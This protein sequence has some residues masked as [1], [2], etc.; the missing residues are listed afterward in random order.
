MVQLVYT[1][2]ARSRM[3]QRHIT[4]EEAQE[5]W[6][7]PEIAYADRRGNL[8]HVGRVRGRRIKVVVARGSDPPKVITVAD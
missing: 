5:A 3:Q 4:E 6:D 2:H 1:A 8:V 7:H